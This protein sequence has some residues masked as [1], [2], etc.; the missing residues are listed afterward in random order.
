M[1][2]LDEVRHRGSL[3]PYYDGHII[4]FES[5]IRYKLRPR[6][7]QRQKARKEYLCHVRL[8]RNILY[9]VFFY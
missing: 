9:L 1:T 3:N 4:D 7:G 8:K 6:R 5:V 2:D